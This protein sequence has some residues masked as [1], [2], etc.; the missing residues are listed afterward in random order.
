[1]AGATGGNTAF[2]P[3][4]LAAL[5]TRMFQMTSAGAMNPAVMGGMGAGYGGGMR[6][7]MMAGMAG[8]S[9]IDRKSTRLNSSHLRRSRMPSSA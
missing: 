7:G 9:G 2:D 3:Q 6:P 5:Y 1:M 4:A 8:M